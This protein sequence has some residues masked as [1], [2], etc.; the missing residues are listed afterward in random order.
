VSDRD[1]LFALCERVKGMEPAD[2]PAG[3]RLRLHELSA[4]VKHR[5]QRL[6][7]PTPRHE[8]QEPWARR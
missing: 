8:G 2:I 5:R 1:A 3:I 6:Q 7:A 4:R